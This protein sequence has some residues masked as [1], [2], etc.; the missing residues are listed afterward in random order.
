MFDNYIFAAKQISV[1]SCDG[2]F[3]SVNLF[4]SW[5]ETTGP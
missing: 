2:R 1:D 4:G 3:N 5:T